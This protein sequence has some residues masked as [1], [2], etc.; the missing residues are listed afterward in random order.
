MSEASRQPSAISRQNGMGDGLQLRRAE[1]VGPVRQTVRRFRRHRL[2]LAG[3]LIV[4]VIVLLAVLAP[5]AARQGPNEID[6]RARNQGPSWSHWFGTDRTGRDTFARTIY[7]GR[8][9]LAVGVVAVAI[10]VAIGAL[11]GALAGFFGGRVDSL[12]MRFTDVIMTFPPIVIILTV[13]ALAGPGVRNTMLVIGLLNWP[14]PCRLVRAKFLAVREMDF[15]TAAR[16]LGAPTRRIITVHAF[17]NVIDVL[18]VYASLGIAT[19][20]LLEAGLSFL[21]LGVQPPTPSWGNMLNPARNVSIL[22]QYPWQWMPAGG[23]IILTVIAVNFVGDG[24]RDALDPRMK[25]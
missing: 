23:A 9:S 17:P 7:A 11:L 16:A 21:G 5:L 24:L 22:E 14:V 13:A 20:I 3:L 25:I 19:A 6:L 15:V 18:V 10:S 8:V 12:V 2:A 4:T 1:V